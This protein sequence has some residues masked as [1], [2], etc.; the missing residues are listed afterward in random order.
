MDS[1]TQAAL[2]AAVGEATL[3]R[4][5]G[6]RAIMWGAIAGTLPDLDVLANPILDEIAQLGWH[7]G[8]SHAF[9]YLTLGAPVL[10]WIISRIHSR[11]G[12]WRRWTALVYLAFVTHVLLDTFTVY[13]TQLFLPF[14]N[15]PA[16]FNSISIIDPL[17]TLP[18]LI[19]LLAAMFFR[20]TRSIRRQLVAVGLIISTG[21]LGATV[22]AKVHVNDVVEQSLSQQQLTG[23][24]YIATPTIFNSILWRATIKTDEGFLVGHYSL[25]DKNDQI[26]FAFIPNDTALISRYAHTDAIRR[27]QWFSRGYMLAYDVNGTARLH[28]LR[29]GEMNHD[30]SAD[31]AFVFGWDLVPSDERHDGWGLRRVSPNIDEPGRALIALWQRMLGKQR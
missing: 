24:E 25:L 9:F 28:D 10:G 17:Y 26:E 1:L 21:Y 19:P 20:K 18:L 5:A 12:S 4:T 3:G 27:L 30:N 8:P 16:A 14:S 31:R 2:G 7:R 11:Y 15:Y 22:A 13:G 6:N 23:A 29:F